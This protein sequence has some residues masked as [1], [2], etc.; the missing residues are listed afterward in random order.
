M[1]PNLNS[2][3][4]KSGSLTLAELQAARQHSTGSVLLHLHRVTV[5]GRDTCN[6]SCQSEAGCDCVRGFPATVPTDHG[7]LGWLDAC[8]PEGGRHAEPVPT[9]R[10]RPGVGIALV[11]A[12]WL[13][14]V[15]GWAVWVRWPLG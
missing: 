8:A 4:I 15:I 2:P 13:L 1:Q 10:S 11:L 12:P 14:G 3:A 5:A 9:K 7:S 6:G